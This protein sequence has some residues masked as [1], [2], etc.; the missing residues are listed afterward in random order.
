VPWNGLALAIHL[1]QVIDKKGKVMSM[2]TFLSNH[3]WL[4]E[5]PI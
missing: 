4:S 3:L 1:L 2:E 5:V